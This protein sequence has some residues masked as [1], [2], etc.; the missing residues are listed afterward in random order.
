MWSVRRQA[1]VLFVV[2][3]VAGLATLFGPE[4]RLGG[5]DLGAT[6]AALFGLVLVA[7]VALFAR[8]AEEIFP[9]GSSVAERRAWIGIF[10]IGFVLLS[11][12]RFMWAL[13]QVT[14][15]PQTLDAIYAKHF[16]QHLFGL[17]LAW[18]LMAYLIARRAGGV[19]LD[20]RDLNLEH[21][22]ERAGDVA[23]T[24]I[25]IGCVCV[26]AFTPVEMLAWWLAPIVLANLLIGLLIA[27]SL[28]EHLVLTFAYF[29]ARR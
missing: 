14:E 19:P 2:G 13:A 5:V 3:L 18:K 4:E 22:A 26:L 9:E 29:A 6:G 12:L 7:A 28:V 1:A 27:R 21:V 15:L 20:E 25:I 11:F 16:L 23:L 8:G 24:A 17:I 10:F